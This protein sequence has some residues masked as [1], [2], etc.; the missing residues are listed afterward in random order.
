MFGLNSIYFETIEK[1]NEYITTFAC[2]GLCLFAVWQGKVGK[3]GRRW[4][5]RVLLT[6]A[7]DSSNVADVNNTSHLLLSS[8]L[9]DETNNTFSC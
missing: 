9:H 6:A 8:W 4:R 2:H 3:G 1:Q 5:G 7:V